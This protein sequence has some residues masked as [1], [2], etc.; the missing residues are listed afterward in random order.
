ME[1][2]FKNIMNAFW[3]KEN[4][5]NPIKN[6]KAYSLRKMADELVKLSENVWAYYGFSREPL[7]GKF[8]FEE[9]MK[10]A[11]NA[12]KCGEEEGRNF[13]NKNMSLTKTAEEMGFKIN[14]PYMPNGGANVTFA[15]YEENGEITVFMDT[16]NK[17]RPLMKENED[18]LGNRDIFDVLLLHELFHGIEQRKA[19]T[20]YTQN[21]KIQLWRKPFSNKSKI[22]CLSE[23]AAMSFAK[24]VLN[25][26]YNPYVFD[27]ILMYL[28]N[29][30]AA[31]MLY[32]EIMEYKEITEGC[33][34]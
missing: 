11:Y 2:K 20:I 7:E 14:T 10:L 13:K 21:E 4:K 34:A 17:A 31:S 29:E 3:G 32:D 33:S 1:N 15:Q 16:V 8:S 23:I 12:V 22:G 26:N 9:K 5:I 24:T 30:E 27:V 25:L 19:D 18:I 6:V 28:Y